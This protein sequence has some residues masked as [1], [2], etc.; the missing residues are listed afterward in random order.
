[1][2]EDGVRV[3]RIDWLTAVPSL[4][5]C[6]AVRF[7]I[8]LHAMLPATLLMWWAGNPLCQRLMAW[9]FTQDLVIRKE[10]IN[11]ADPQLSR[12]LQTLNF[13]VQLIATGTSLEV[14]RSFISL[15]FCMLLFSFCAIPVMRSAGSRFC[16]GGGNNLLACVK[17]SLQ[18]WK[19]ILVSSLLSCLLL[20]FLCVA[21]R[22][23]RW[24]GDVT[25]SGLTLLAAL[26]YV[27]GVFVLGFG[28]LLSLAAIAI[29]RCD[30]A[31]ALSRGI[32]Y[33]LSRWPRVI[34]YAFVGY[35]LITVCQT[36][37]R[38]LARLAHLTIWLADDTSSLNAYSGFDEVIRMSIFFC[39][40]AIA[41]VLLRNVEDGVSLR[42]I[43]G[44]N[45]GDSVHA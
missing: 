42:E 16:S 31:E 28:W 8:S 44:G 41:Y 30:G 34:I 36:V 33:V 29:D 12:L 11:G 43:D 19:A 22:T 25:F 7:A 2:N 40:I 21:F 4:R 17:L 3:I 14:L 9:N 20:C 39:E 45:P 26:I 35:A 18:S 24:I 32:S 27:A 37:F 1:M 6:E 13:K 23:T 10:S 38:W 5:L 15:A